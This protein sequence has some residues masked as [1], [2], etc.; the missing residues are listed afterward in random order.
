M[1]D[2]IGLELRACA[3]QGRH[4]GQSNQDNIGNSFLASQ[5]SQ[6]IDR[7]S[8]LDDL[9]NYRNIGADKNIEMCGLIG[10]FM[11]PQNA[12]R[13]LCHVENVPELSLVVK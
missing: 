12:Y 11:L 1:R 13:N 10:R 3:L 7:M 8:S 4:I 6:L 9:M 5:G 2:L